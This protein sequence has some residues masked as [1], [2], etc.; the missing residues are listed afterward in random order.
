[1]FY[2]MNFNGTV[3]ALSLPHLSESVLITNINQCRRETLYFEGPLLASPFVLLSVMPHSS[4]LF[5]VM[6]PSSE[7]LACPAWLHCAGHCSA[8]VAI[9][10]WTVR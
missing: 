3:T 6:S 4:I 7:L 2:T 9:I 5:S 8:F 1:M 10:G